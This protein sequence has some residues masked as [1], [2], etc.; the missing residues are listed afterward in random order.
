ML[1][2]N[3][4]TAFTSIVGDVKSVDIAKSFQ[5]MGMGMLGIFIVML[6]IFLVIVIL[7]KTTGGKKN[8]K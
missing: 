4:L 3:L 6:L 7:N 8:D 5:L 1:N 2:W